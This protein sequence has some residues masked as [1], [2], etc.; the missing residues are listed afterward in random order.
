M[1]VHNS[2][3]SSGLHLMCL[4]DKRH[5]YWTHTSHTTHFHHGLRSS[6]FHSDVYLHI[7]PY[8]V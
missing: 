6:T 2:H 1:T 3:F 8:M 7:Q 4:S 5:A